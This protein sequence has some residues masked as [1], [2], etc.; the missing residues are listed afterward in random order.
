VPPLLP[1]QNAEPRTQR[2]WR[3]P[4]Q[5]RQR[6]AAA[7]GPPELAE[8]RCAP[9]GTSS[10][11]VT[12]L[13]STVNLTVCRQTCSHCC[14]RCRTVSCE[15]LGLE[16]AE[17]I[18]RAGG[19]LVRRSKR[20]Q[21]LL[22]P[23]LHL[24]ELP[25]GDTPAWM[26]ACGWRMVC[27]L[28]QPEDLNTSLS[29]ALTPFNPAPGHCADQRPAGALAAIP[30]GALLPDAL[31]AAPQQHRVPSPPLPWHACRLVSAARRS[32]PLSPAAV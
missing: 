18:P 26:D 1:T 31:P 12:N 20:R 4:P 6:P 29:S 17:G 5:L 2:P 25:V 8:A 22:L 28:R 9:G 7:P 19:L 16:V 3:R 30:P 24:V 23:R 11:A 15:H 13:H 10:M 27:K 21:Q 14:R 32:V